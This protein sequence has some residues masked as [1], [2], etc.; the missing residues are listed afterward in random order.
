MTTSMTTMPKIFEH[1]QFGNLR[2]ITDENTGEPWFVASDV[3]KGLGYENPSRSVNTHCK[4][5]NKFSPTKL[6]GTPIN[7]IPESDVYR[8][9]MR[10]NLPT[11][12]RFQDWVMEEVLPSIRKSGGYL[13]VSPDDSPDAILAR[14][15]LVAQDTIERIKNQNRELEE[16]NEILE[17]TIAYTEAGRTLAER[18]R[19]K[20]LE[21]RAKYEQRLKETEPKAAL[22]DAAFARPLGLVNKFNRL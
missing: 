1:Q 22:V 19:D 16:R 3:A 13:V 6:V 20:A 10:S 12:E 8:L 5:V 7:I 17:A 18:A 21:A 4:N 11:A 14:A 15:V 2:V 9:I